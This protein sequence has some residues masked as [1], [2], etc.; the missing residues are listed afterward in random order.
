M[1]GQGKIKYW[2]TRHGTHIP[3]YEKEET[4]KIG[5]VM[6]AAKER[7]PKITQKD[8][9]TSID[10][11]EKKASKTDLSEATI[12]KYITQAQ[13]HLQTIKERKAYAHPL[14]DIDK[15]LASQQRL[16]KLLEKLNRDYRN[17][18]W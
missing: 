11:L 3:V 16:E 1:K 13:N 17:N 4:K 6:A 5:K 9:F 8:V 12:K 10:D 2:F 7:N 14:E 15:L 18:Q